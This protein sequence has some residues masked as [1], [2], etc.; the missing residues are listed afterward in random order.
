MDG[1]QN[2][3]FF[4]IFIKKSLSNGTIIS[5]AVRGFPYNVRR[6]R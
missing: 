3:G 5:F 6:K 2:P 1:L 4:K